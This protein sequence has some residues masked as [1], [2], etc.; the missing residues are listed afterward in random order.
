MLRFTKLEITNFGPYQSTQTVAFPSE[1]GVVIIWGKNGIGKTSIMKAIHFALW[2]NIEDEHGE[3]ESIA[4][5]VNSEAVERDED[6]SVVL[7]MT[8]DGEDYTLTRCLERRKDTSGKNDADY[9]FDVFLQKGADIVS[10]NE[11]DHFLRMAIPEDIARFYL[12]DGELLRQYESL[13]KSGND[14][15]IIKDSIE[16]ILGLPIL[17]ISKNSLEIIKKE[18]SDVFTKASTAD[19]RTKQAGEKLK[20]LEEKEEEFKKSGKE[21]E[22]LLK[23]AITKLGE[24]DIALENSETYR[25]YTQKI[26][27]CA[28]AIAE[29]TEEL[30]EAAEDI[31]EKLENIWEA[32]LKTVIENEIATK[33]EKRDAL[34]S[35]LRTQNENRAIYG[36]LKKII[37][38]H[39]SGCP[40]PICDSLIDDTAIGHI[41][42]KINSFAD[43]GDNTVIKEHSELEAEIHILKGLKCEDNSADIKSDLKTIDK[44]HTKIQ[45]KELEKENLENDRRKVGV[46]SDEK[47]I[48]NLMPEHDRLTGLINTY[49]DGIAKNTKAIEEN[50]AN[51]EKV[52]LQIKKNQSNTEV[53]TSRKEFELCQSIHVL[54]EEAIEQFKLDLKESVQKD[55]TAYFRSVA[56]N[57]DYKELTINEEYG[58]EIMTEKGVRVPHRS[59]GYVQVVAISLIAALHKNAP[60]SGPIVMDSTFQ[61]IDA[62]HKSNILASLPTLG[63][64][65]IV[66]AY[67][68]EIQDT[69]VRN[70]LKGKLRK[71]ITLEQLSSFNTIIAK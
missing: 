31:K 51:M 26:K 53:E 39:K 12:F 62:E 18:Y 48:E 1:D 40:C 71:E 8:Y 69:V 34:A 65:V 9:G 20:G 59:S 57:P 46:D 38:D 7:H 45:L 68:E 61:R 4:S 21:L 28:E 24:V 36:I 6:M 55:A 52:R 66:L 5:Y 60:I 30:E 63:R 32:H 19:S 23:D 42:S 17:E 70:V 14:N 29:A 58:L 47:D 3:E 15:T 50:K 37:E 56:H 43:S 41:E 11:R 2:G 35:T 49:K 25:S 44:L 16:D 33:E 22:A 10:P 54:F 67:P 27:S 64:Q 13:L